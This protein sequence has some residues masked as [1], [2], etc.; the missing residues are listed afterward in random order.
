MI[1]H[2]KNINFQTTPEELET[3]FSQFG[4][5]ERVDIPKDR[6]TKLQQGYA[7]IHFESE[8]SAAEAIKYIDKTTFGGREISVQP[9]IKNTK[10]NL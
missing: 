6:R 4:S 7:F 9:S 1:I 8:I 5:I 3:L 10:N 2:V